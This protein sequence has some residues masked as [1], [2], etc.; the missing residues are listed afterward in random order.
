MLQML[1][2]DINSNQT[3]I[4]AVAAPERVSIIP[5]VPTTKDGD[6]KPHMSSAR[7]YGLPRV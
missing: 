7:G 1:L 6:L 2:R 3:K 4:V 5:E